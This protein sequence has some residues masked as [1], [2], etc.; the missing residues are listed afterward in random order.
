MKPKISRQF[1]ASLLYHLQ[2]SLGETFTKLPP[3]FQQGYTTIFWNNLSIT[4]ANRHTQAKNSWKTS[5]EE[6]EVLFGDAQ[7]FRDVNTNG[8][9]MSL[10][11]TAHGKRK[12]YYKICHKN[13]AGAVAH[14][15]TKWIMVI[16]QGY[17][18]RKGHK[19]VLNAYQVSSTV[20]T[21]L[22]EW[23]DSSKPLEDIPSG[24]GISYSNLENI[25]KEKTQPEEVNILV[26]INFM[27]L[28]E[29]QYQLEIIQEEFFKKKGVSEALKGSTLWNDIVRFFMD[30]DDALEERMKGPNDREDK[31][32]GIVTPKVNT[33][34]LQAL[35]Q[36]DLTQKN[37][38]Q[39]LSYINKILL[40][41]R[42]E[43]FEG[44]PMTYEVVSTG[45]LFA[46]N[47]TLQ[48]YNK[49]V[50]YAAL[51][52]CYAY[53]MES[54]HQSILLQLLEE[55]SANFSELDILREYVNEKKAVRERLSKELGLPIKA[56][57]DILQTLTYGARLSRSR[58][59]AVYKACS[60]DMEAVEKVVTHPWLRQYQQTFNQ[61][62]EILLGNKKTFKNIKGLP[63]K[64]TSKPAR[65]A[66]LLQGHER[67]VIDAL[68]KRSEKGMVALLLH[69]A[70]VFYGKAETEQ[71]EEFVKHD[72]G[73]N[74]RFSEE[75][76]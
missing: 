39:Q 44:I 66:H 34:P 55:E 30:G 74:L 40:A 57:K 22:D 31:G 60:G 27:S 28:K 43:N 45:R 51:Q 8:Y 29:Y 12:G 5:A 33:K 46:T 48:G 10:K 6:L 32:W 42:E 14:N 69:D 36:K 72:T 18:P 67:F 3:R 37:I 70:I 16:S 71:L 17:G 75:V 62:H 68:I 73:F 13:D 58:N 19:G 65:L 47:A 59:E 11:R 15:P 21:I 52:G 7:A 25:A 4:D 53:D 35:L 50:R 2:N 38:S 20:Q 61:A 41:Y 24:F 1:P 9:Y 23:G 64:K 54:A 63:C 49:E 76:Y 56:V 26:R